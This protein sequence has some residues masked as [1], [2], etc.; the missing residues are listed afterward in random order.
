MLVE[1]KSAALSLCSE[2]TYI[3]THFTSTVHL[4][5][6]AR[7]ICTRKIRPRIPL[8]FQH[9]DQ[10]VALEPMTQE[11]SGRHPQRAVQSARRATCERLSSVRGVG[12]IDMSTC[13]I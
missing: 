6:N 11:Q 7:E 3:D 12:N 13:G 5:P 10:F 9:P 2:F 4:F 1:S 8:I